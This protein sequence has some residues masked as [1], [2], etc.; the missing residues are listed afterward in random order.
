MDKSS[1]FAVRSVCVG[2]KTQ[3]RVTRKEEAVSRSAGHGKIRVAHIFSMA[4]IRIA[5][6]ARTRTTSLIQSSRTK[7]LSTRKKRREINKTSECRSRV[8][9]ILPSDKL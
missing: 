7:A 4:T 3:V 5:Y 6:M 1:Q 2:W 8:S 9:V